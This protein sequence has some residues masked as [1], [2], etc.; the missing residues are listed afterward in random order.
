MVMDF[1]GLVQTPSCKDDLCCRCRRNIGA[2]TIVAAL[3]PC[4]LLLDLANLVAKLA[5]VPELLLPSLLLLQGCD[6]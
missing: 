3:E 5:Q 6:W 1:A 2:E 4:E